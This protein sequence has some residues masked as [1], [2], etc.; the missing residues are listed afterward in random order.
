MMHK[1]L[2]ERQEAILRILVE[3]YIRCAKPVPSQVLV[4]KYHLGY[5]SATIRIDMKS[6]EED[7]LVFQRHASGGRI[8]TDL[9]YRYFVE[10]LM[11]ESSLLPDEQRMIRHQF[12][13]VQHQLD[14][15]V[16]LSASIMAQAIK[17]AAAVVTMPR[18]QEG[19][20]KHFA[21][22]SLYDAIA[23]LV[24]ILQDGSDTQCRIY[25]T[26][27]ATQDDLDQLA[28][29]LNARFAGGS[30]ADLDRV[31]A[32]DATYMSPNERTVVLALAQALR[33]HDAWG[34][35][36]VYQEG[37]TRILEEPEFTSIGDERERNERIRKVVDALEQHR[38]LPLLGVQAAQEQGIQV[39]IGGETAQEDL[40]DVSLV[41]SRYGLP[42]Q[43][44]GVLGLIGPTRM[45]YS[46]AVAVVR[47]MTE[48]MNDLLADL[49]GTPADDPPDE[50]Q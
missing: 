31:I 39:M 3:E 27:P 37:L 5:S 46:R 40:R 34:P 50:S 10:R 29:R 47:Y 41:V 25:L 1:R 30:A 12:Y 9:G 16:R 26:D 42:G 38:L 23:L 20:L 49:Y 7:G 24:V 32:D 4:D 48:I 6:L 35:A 22:L 15:W 14:Q 36:D 28:A 43:T 13:Q 33:Q 11:Q 18:G 2:T 44:G 19:R 17:G 21:L 8:P 45:Q